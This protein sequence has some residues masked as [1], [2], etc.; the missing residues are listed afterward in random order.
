MSE[1]TDWKVTATIDRAKV[2]DDIKELLA[3]LQK[4]RDPSVIVSANDEDHALM[5]GVHRI[6]VHLK[7]PAEYLKTVKA[8]RLQ[9]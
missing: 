2:V 5:E 9:T 7:V 4:A 8:R 3:V 6:K 1:K